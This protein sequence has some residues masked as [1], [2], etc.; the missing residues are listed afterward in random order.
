MP[1]EYVEPKLARRIRDRERMIARGRRIAARWHE[2]PRGAFGS[3]CRW[4]DLTRRY[5]EGLSTWDDVFAIRDVYA[6]LN[7]DHLKVCSGLRCCA[8]PRRR[9]QVSLQEGRA[10]PAAAAQLADLWDAGPPRF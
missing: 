1:A 5:R 8:N 6:R 3:R 2:A 4:R 7:H 9:G 10:A